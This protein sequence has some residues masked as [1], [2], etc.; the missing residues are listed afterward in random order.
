MSK[1]VSMFL[2]LSVTGEGVP[3]LLWLLLELTQKRMSK[4]LMYLF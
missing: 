1:Y 4:Q 2:P 3:D